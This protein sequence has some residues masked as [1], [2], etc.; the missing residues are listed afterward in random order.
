V[1]V[2]MYVDY[3]TYNVQ[4]ALMTVAFTPNMMS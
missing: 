2:C 1:Y 3:R 4:G